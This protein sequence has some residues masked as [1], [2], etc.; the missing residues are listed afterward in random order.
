MTTQQYI[1]PNAI[2]VMGRPCLEDERGAFVPLSQI[3]PAE[4]LEDELVGKLLDFAKPLS[5]ELARLKAYSFAD[6]EAF[7]GLLAQDYNV[8]RRTKKGNLTLYSYDRRRKVEIKSSDRIVFGAQ[9][10]MAKAKVDECLRKWG[11]TIDP[12]LQAII[13]SAFDVDR[14]GA[15]RPA[16]ILLLRRAHI[17]DDPDWDQAMRAIDAA[18][19]VVGTSFYMLFRER[20]GD[21]DSWNRISLEF[22]NVEL[23]PEAEAAFSARKELEQAEAVLGEI[24]DEMFFAPVDMPKDLVMAGAVGWL[25]E[26]LW[27]ARGDLQVLAQR[28][29][30]LEPMFGDVL[31][32][33]GRSGVPKGPGMADDVG[34][35][36]DQLFVARGE[37]ELLAQQVDELQAQIAELTAEPEDTDDHMLPPRLVDDLYCAD[38]LLGMVLPHLE[39]AAQREGADVDKIA[40]V[41]CELKAN[42]H[43][44][45]AMFAEAKASTT[46]VAE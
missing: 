31:D 4:L 1:H 33:L 6:V 11:A 28:T 32:E 45:Q 23:T 17:T 20:V 40:G 24:R 16:R 22:S 9:L 25:V 14:E 3:A 2:D 34:N 5:A 12:R 41:V 10:Q 13:N 18:M 46:Q 36:V 27:A 30:I 15:V 44:I 7:L 21:T 37:L 39:G 35:L 43:V 29:H 19:R 26:Q 42:A 8:E 38:E